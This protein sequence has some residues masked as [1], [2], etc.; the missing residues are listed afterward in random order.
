[1]SLHEEVE[2][3]QPEPV[4]LGLN[5]FG[6]WLKV[7]EAVA[8]C[9]LKGLNRT[10]KTIRKWAMRSFH[11]PESAEISVRR[12]DIETGFRWSIEKISLDRKIEQ[13]L[14]F[15]ARKTSELVLT[16]PAEH[17]QVRP[18]SGQEIQQQTDMNQ[19]EHVQTGFDENKGSKVDSNIEKELRSQ[20]SQLKSEVDFY[21][22]E[23]RDRRQAATALTDVIKAFRLNAENNSTSKTRT[24]HHDIRPT[25]TP[26]SGDREEGE[27]GLNHVQ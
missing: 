2:A 21:R 23:L 22:E 9:S 17:T 24:E 7:S 5:P 4:Q 13:E 20:L 16:D 10:P 12:E 14:E 18:S 15:E 3:N 26:S 27:A 11:N 6:S 8:Y 1:M 19:Q 25:R